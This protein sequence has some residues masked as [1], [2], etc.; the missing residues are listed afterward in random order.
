MLKVSSK[1]KANIE[2]EYEKEVN[3]NEFKGIYMNDNHDTKFYEGGAHFRYRDLCHILE[4]LVKT[5]APDRKGK[6][7]YEDWKE[8][9]SKKID[10]KFIW[11]IN[12]QLI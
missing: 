5:L 2:E 6:S 7:M 12:I 9:E 11:L 8:D 4:K 10:G 1:I 3:L